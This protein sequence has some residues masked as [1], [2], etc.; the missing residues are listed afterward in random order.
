MF[1]C[2]PVCSQ[3]EWEMLDEHESQTLACQIFQDKWGANMKIAGKWCGDTQKREPMR[4]RRDKK[5][6]RT[7]KKEKSKKSPNSNNE[8]WKRTTQI[9][10]LSGQTLFSSSH[11]SRDSRRKC[12]Y[13][14]VSACKSP[15]KKSRL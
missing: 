9:I 7:R 14:V 6:E 11:S 1:F 4:E 3:D 2:T 10:G 8:W 12:I 13:D 5:R 15:E